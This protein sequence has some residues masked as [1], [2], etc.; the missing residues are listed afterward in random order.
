MKYYIKSGKKTEEILSAVVRQQTIIL[1][2]QSLLKSV[3]IEGSGKRLSITLVPNVG[4]V[5]LLGSRES[6][7]ILIH[8]SLK[9]LIIVLCLGSSKLNHAG[10][11]ICLYFQIN[12]I[13]T[14]DNGTP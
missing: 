12:D 4:I 5:L 11:E 8:A 3:N 9:I 10:Q 14:M 7:N 6:L 2:H 13:S 1:A